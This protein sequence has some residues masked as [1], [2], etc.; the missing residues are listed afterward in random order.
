MSSFG[1][2]V[3]VF[4]LAIGVIAGGLTAYA[5]WTERRNRK[6]SLEALR[7]STPGSDKSKIIGD[8]TVRDYISDH[9]LARH[10]DEYFA[11]LKPNENAI[12]AETDGEP[13]Q[14]QG[15]SAIDREASRE[16][17]EREARYAFA[18]ARLPDK[19]EMDPILYWNDV[20]LE[21][22]RVSHTNG[23]E[24]QTG[25]TLS[26]R[27][28]GIVHL[29]MY[30]AFAGASDYPADL[31]AYLGVSAPAGAPLAEQAIKAAV[32]AA[33]HT[34]LSSLFKSQKAFFDQ[35]YAQA[36]PAD[37]GLAEGHQF[38]V[39]VAQ[40]ILEDRK[41]DPDDSDE[42]YV[43][44]VGRGRHRPDPDNPD[45]GFHAPFYGE[46]SKLFAVTVRHQLAD[47]PQP[48]D[49]DY[50]SA[51]QEVRAQGIAPELMETLPPGFS[52]R[53]VNQT[54][55]GI[56]WAYDGASGLG[57]P[58]R[59]YNQIV[60]EVAKNKNNSPQENARLFAL[61]N[62]AMADAGI[63]AWDEK[64][65][66]D[67]WRPVVGIREHDA[68]TGPT[69]V[70][71]NAIGA[72]CDTFWLPL[73]APKTNETGKKN[74]TPPFPAYPSGHATFGAAAFHITRLFYGVP[75]GDR[76]PDNLFEGLE[77]VSDEM[78]GV[79]KDNKGTVRPR[80]VRN[81]PRGLW[82]MIIQ[83]GR[84]RVDLGVNWVFDTFVEDP[85]GRPDLTQ[86]V[87]GV[88]LGLTIA[89]DI[90]DSGMQKSTVGPRV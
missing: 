90:F 25:P 28:L 70:G 16:G 14:A 87:G 47:A 19:E 66:H 62:V 9:E 22:N 31:P 86:N 50:L 39:M 8:L 35:A 63:L 64:Y 42:G 53:T 75:L 76:N 43:A 21:A 73:G 1:V 3:L 65:R 23:T 40:A 54:L 68:S 34:T 15:E 26:S 57:T 29:A 6:R 77:F 59:L 41:D 33:A 2:F 18:E 44:S 10:I 24:E 58:P 78:N 83:N 61:V 37:A 82:Q 84:S 49:P 12:A 20:A 72:D 7:S 74:V 80:H 4:G 55:R 67:L 51:L 38:G 71:N 36:G 5:T 88:P 89:E 17:Q 46:R 81:F 60:R 27:A 32:A 48:G 69:G 79:N 30:D 56:Y 85:S 45:Q 52:R 11:H 13:Q